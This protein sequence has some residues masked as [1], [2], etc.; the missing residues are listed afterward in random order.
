[1]TKCQVFLM[2]AACAALLTGCASAPST[3]IETP[4]RAAQFDIALDWFYEIEPGFGK[5]LGATPLELGGVK[6]IGL[7]TLAASSGG[8]VLAIDNASARQV[9][10]KDFEMPVTAGPVVYEN[11]VFVALGN[12]SI[13]KLNLKTGETVW[14]YE[15]GVAV[16]NGLSVADGIVACVNANNRIFAIDEKTGTLKWRKERPRSQDF[17]MYGQSAPLISDEMVYAGYSDG[18]VVAYA[19][20]NGTALWS[21]ELA[22]NARFKDV[23]A[24]PIRV[25][26]TIFVASSSGG[27]YALSADDGQTLWQRDIYGISSI[28]HFQDSLY[29]SSQSG[30]F[31][32]NR[33]TGDTIWQN[34]VQK[35]ALISPL[36]L[37][38]NAIYAAVQKYGLIVLDRANGDLMHVIDMGSDFTSAPDFMPG[39]ITAMS[40]RSTVYR[41]FVDDE[42]VR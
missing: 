39:V 33:I 2:C 1:M 14:H 10:L 24:P 29:I 8:K 25:G 21:R 26:N 32:L 35:E 34:V 7:I 22:P 6:D 16:E 36:V 3:Q 31:R 4:P 13:L 20:L 17:S 11:G 19:A 38:K 23:D 28:R 37:G 40:N 27:I 30:I 18:T 9:W 42:P 15:A 5:Y 41:Y 12:G